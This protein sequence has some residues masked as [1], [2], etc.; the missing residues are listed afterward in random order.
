MPPTCK[1]PR[2]P[3][4]RPRGDKH[5]VVRAGTKQLRLAGEIMSDGFRH[6]G[7]TTDSR[8]MER[9]PAIQGHRG[10]R[11]FARSDH[12]PATSFASSLHGQAVG[13]CCL[14]AQLGHHGA[15]DCC[16]RA[17]IAGGAAAG[18]PGD[19]GAHPY[20]EAPRAV[21]D[22]RQAGAG[23]CDGD[24][25]NRRRSSGG[26]ESKALDWEQRSR[27]D[28]LAYHSQHLSFLNQRTVMEEGVRLVTRKARP[29]S[30]P[31]VVARAPAR[32]AALIADSLRKRRRRPDTRECC[33]TY[34]RCDY[35]AVSEADRRC[36][37]A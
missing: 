22:G 23:S 5:R 24:F 30:T 15:F 1:L 32:P 2:Q 27:L 18:L 14:E 13:G 19:A 31:R 17:V 25:R 29:S 26:A 35:C 10:A 34:R 3:T 7:K 20:R 4:R 37:G 16:R 11:R 36:A 6:H 28:R 8:D 33:S 12:A 9:R 21:R